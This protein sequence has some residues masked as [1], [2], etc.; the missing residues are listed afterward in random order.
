MEARKD[1]L[2]AASHLV[3]AVNDLAKTA[4]APL[5][6]SV[7]R[8]EIEPN[9]PNTV[10]ER[11]RLWVELRS[12]DQEALSVALAGFKAK[13]GELPTLTGCGAEITSETQRPVAVFD[14]VGL[15]LVEMAVTKAGFGAM[16]LSTIAGH[17]AISLQTICPTTLIFVPS[18]DGISHSP[19]EFTSDQEVIA[20]YEASLAAI[21]ALLTVPPF[22]ADPSVPHES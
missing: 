18:K 8:M 12:D 22:K 13:L 1:A 15:D 16:R 11:V 14:K 6:S 5:H 9:S 20:G 4:S 7:G 3:V 10:A 21:S 19:E 2:V 17:D